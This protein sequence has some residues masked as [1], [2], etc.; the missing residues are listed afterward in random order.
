MPRE[1]WLDKLE[2][3]HRRGKHDP[4]GGGPHPDCMLC[5]RKEQPRIDMLAVMTDELSAHL[6]KV[7]WTEL[8]RAILVLREEALALQVIADGRK[9]PRR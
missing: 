2:K 7:V 8:G 6:R 5:Q 3:Q 9:G 1:V 4:D